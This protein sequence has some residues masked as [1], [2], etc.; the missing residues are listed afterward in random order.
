MLALLTNRLALTAIGG[1]GVVAA[2]LFLLFW[3]GSEAGKKAAER[4][5]AE[6]TEEIDDPK[7]GWRA[8]LSRC[9]ASVD[10]LTVALERQNAAVSQLE[11]ESEERTRRANAAIAAAQK[12][13]GVYKRRAEI[14]ANAI[15]SGDLC[16]SA[17]SLIVKT[18][19]EDRP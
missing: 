18:L 6:L 15:P 14:I 12:Q 7:T 11:A 4:R 8:K 16:Q 5:V 3:M 13:V 19:R 17:Q 10:N 2:I 1:L 9:E